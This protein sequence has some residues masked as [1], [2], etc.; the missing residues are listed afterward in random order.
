MDDVLCIGI[1]KMMGSYVVQAPPRTELGSEQFTR[2]HGF[3]TS[4]SG[5]GG[6]FGFC[7]PKTE[8]VYMY[9][10]NR[11]LWYGPM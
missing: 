1:E 3:G 9:V 4:D 2:H 11:L 7:N 6:S 8:I 10:M 5:A